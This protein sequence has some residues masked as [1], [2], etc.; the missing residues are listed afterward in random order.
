MSRLPSLL[1][2]RWWVVL[3]L[4]VLNAWVA[5][6][7]TDLRNR[8][9]P[10]WEAIAPVAYTPRLG[11]V[12]DEP[13]MTRLSEGA[14]GALEANSQALEATN[15]LFTWETA[16]IETD[17]RT[18]RL[19]FIGRGATTEEA[20]SRA[21]ELRQR[22]VDAGYLDEAR[23][24]ELDDQLDRILEQLGELRDRIDAATATEPVDPAI[25][26]QRALLMD[27]FSSLRARH[28]SLRTQVLAPPE[29]QTIESIETELEAVRNR[30]GE[31]HAEL[32]SLPP[33]PTADGS[34]G[35]AESAP[36]LEESLPTTVDMLQYEQLQDVYR[37]LFIR[38]LEAASAGSIQT[39][40]VRESTLQPIS[41]ELNQAAG[42]LVGIIAALVGLVI[43]D[44]IRGPLWSA[45]EVEEVPVIQELPPRPLWS[46]QARPWYVRTPPSDRKAGIQK[47]RSVVE[48]LQ[49]DRGVTI[50]IS[51][52]SAS[53]EDVHELAADL[54]VS[55]AVT[56]RRVL[57]IDA[58]VD[59]P[60][61]LVEF[62]HN[63]VTLAEL[64]RMPTDRPDTAA[65][66]I[67]DL[68]AANGELVP[69]MHAVPAG[70]HQRD[71][72][73]TLSRPDFEVVL[74]TARQR[75]EMIIV[76]GAD[77]VQPSSHVLSQ[78]L[79]AMIVLGA[80]GRTTASTLTSV[81]RSLADRRAR[82]L[83]MVLLTRSFGMFRRT[84]RR[85]RSRAYMRGTTSRRPR[86]DTTNRH[87]TGP[88]RHPKV[89]LG[90]RLWPWRRSSDNEPAHA[91]DEKSETTS[92]RSSAQS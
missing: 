79:D 9:L 54:A 59:N 25:E 60:S 21:E 88:Y 53:A 50:G 32:G 66:E 39:T 90:V 68:M 14:A 20:E 57:L 52:V 30:L 72:A 77:A 81:A 37:E 38:R 61:G 2:T 80:T 12:D 75:F 23:I 55:L 10:E 19:L 6:Y 49:G 87:T 46:S 17:D 78:R 42:A 26:L 70:N 28:A 73:D 43:T 18:R 83:G 31:L 1:R 69:N 74:E 67:D 7:L 35:E 4:A 22:F 34:P 92:P 16:A 63:G 58:D 71:A 24:G 47:L 65:R 84:A 64:L 40:F 11:E 5:A 89:P 86:S 3:G 29:D 62:G 15:G 91:T 41:K 27:E 51:G 13:V 44:R 85:L 56:G 76:T 36:P 8:E 45:G 48:V 33:P 82:L